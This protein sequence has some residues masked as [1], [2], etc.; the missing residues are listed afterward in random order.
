MGRLRR[1]RMHKDTKDIRKKYRLRRKTKDIL[2]YIL[3][4]SF[5]LPC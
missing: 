3:L 1:K 2:L 4:Y 5:E